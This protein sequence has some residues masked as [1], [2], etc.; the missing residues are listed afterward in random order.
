MNEF[1][2]I[3][4]S[5]KVIAEM[6]KLKNQIET[7]NLKIKSNSNKKQVQILKKRKNKIIN[8][9]SN[10]LVKHQKLQEMEKNKSSIEVSHSKKNIDTDLLSSNIEIL[11]LSIRSHNSLIN[12]GITTIGDLIQYNERDLLRIPNFGQKSQNEV[13]RQSKP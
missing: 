9:L 13:M 11:D 1:A 5:K 4:K 12:Q 10:L 2:K 7:L 3:S 6:V 8:L